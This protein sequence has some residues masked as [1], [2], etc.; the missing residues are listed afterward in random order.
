MRP[1][2]RVDTVSLLSQAEGEECLASAID[3]FS[4]RHRDLSGV[5]AKNAG[6]LEH[7]LAGAG[8]P[9][10][11]RLQLIGAPPR[12]TREDAVECAALFNTPWSSAINPVRRA[13]QARRPSGRDSY[14]PRPGRQRA[15]CFSDRELGV[16]RSR[17]RQRRLAATSTAAPAATV[18]RMSRSTVIESAAST[19][20]SSAGVKDACSTMQ[21][22]TLP[23]RLYNQV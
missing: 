20:W 1:T 9:C 7:R 15:G 10:A 11:G 8:R 14:T 6:L 16:H 23:V 5:W 4:H 3:S 18:P 21:S 13:H 22:S 12:F 2:D 19:R 17:R